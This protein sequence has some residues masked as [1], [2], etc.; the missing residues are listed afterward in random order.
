MLCSTGT[1]TRISTLKNI[2]IAQSH[3]LLRQ[4][5][6]EQSTYRRYP[7]SLDSYLCTT[8][9]W[10]ESGMSRQ[11]SPE[12]PADVGLNSPCWLISS[13]LV[14]IQKAFHQESLPAAIHITVSATDPHL[15]CSDATGLPIWYC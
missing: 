5:S 11:L 8:L 15:N 10:T 2:P 6:Q 13:L 7:C 1:A 14:Q 12:R 9:L 4:K 3:V